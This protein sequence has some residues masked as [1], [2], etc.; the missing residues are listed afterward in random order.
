MA[1]AL[2][3]ELA[4]ALVLELAVALVLELAVA[5]VLELA[6][7]FDLNRLL[8]LGGAALQRCDKTSIDKGFSPRGPDFAL[9]LHPRS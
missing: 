7:T 3:L 9:S 1:V 5:L 8:L 2:V 4:V 6:V